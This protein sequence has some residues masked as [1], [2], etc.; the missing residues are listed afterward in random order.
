MQHTVAL[1]VL[2]LALAAS[3]S[4]PAAADQTVV[5]ESESIPVTFVGFWTGP[6]SQILIVVLAVPDQAPEPAPD[7]ESDQDKN[8]VILEDGAPF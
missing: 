8:G 1:T 2:V 6:G 5:E 7:S 4:W 3:A